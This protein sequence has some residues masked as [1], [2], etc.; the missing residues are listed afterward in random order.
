MPG[1]FELFL[2]PVC[3]K[4]GYR[5]PYIWENDIRDVDFRF[6]KNIEEINRYI[7]L[8]YSKVY[9]EH[10]AVDYFLCQPE[11]CLSFDLNELNDE[12]ELPK[13]IEASKRV[14]QP[15]SMDGIC[16]YFR[17]AFDEEIA[18][19]N[20]PLHTRTNWMKVLFRT[21]SKHYTIGEVVSFR[22]TMDVLFN[23]D[24]WSLEVY[25]LAG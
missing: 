7:R 12:N 20:S 3:L 2:E 1:K 11:P 24:T 21:E 6:L 25:P 4:S 14:I 17:V 23:R 5:A 15:G 18:L 16:L 19:D 22:L 13:F 9:I 10:S 8:D